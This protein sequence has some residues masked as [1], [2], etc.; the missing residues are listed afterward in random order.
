[1]GGTVR[2][3]RPSSSA[4]PPAVPVLPTQCTVRSP[5]PAPSTRPAGAGPAA[6][7]LTTCLPACLPAPFRVPSLA[8]APAKSPKGEVPR[9]RSAPDGVCPMCPAGVSGCGVP[10]SA[11]EVPRLPVLPCGGSSFMEG[12]GYL[13]S[14]PVL[15]FRV[16]GVWGAGGRAVRVRLFA[17]LR[18]GGTPASTPTRDQPC[19][20]VRTLRG[21]G[22]LASA[23]TRDQPYAHVRTPR[24]SSTLASAETPPASD[25]QMRWPSAQG[26]LGPSSTCLLCA[27]WVRPLGCPPARKACIQ[28]ALALAP[29]GCIQ[30]RRLAREAC[31]QPALSA[32]EAC[33][34]DGASSAPK[35]CMENSFFSAHEAKLSAHN[36]TRR[37]RR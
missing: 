4:A 7:N 15:P 31:I 19:V 30:N 37:G 1:M 8:C 35:R 28:P 20:H 27:L 24:S 14:A 29:K 10:G 23:E 18:P 2:S 22:T 36:L 5:R 32:P 16:H 11:P 25:G 12:T 33:I 17:H 13:R 26:P 34:R 9:L 21:S 6:H 3:S